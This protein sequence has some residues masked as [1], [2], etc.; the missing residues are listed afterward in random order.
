MELRGAAVPS[1][2]RT[3]HAL[4]ETPPDQEVCSRDKHGAN[5]R[6]VLMTTFPGQTAENAP[7]LVREA[8]LRPQAQDQK[9]RRNGLLRVEDSRIHGVQLLHQVLP[10]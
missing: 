4:P 2:R 5:E 3:I 7:T 6:N 1:G 9:D 10:R 8:V